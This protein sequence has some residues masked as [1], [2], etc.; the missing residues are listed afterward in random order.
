MP[1]TPLTLFKLI[2]RAVVVAIVTEDHHPQGV[3]SIIIERRWSMTTFNFVAIAAV[4]QNESSTH[5]H[6]I[7]GTLRESEVAPFFAQFVLV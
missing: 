5:R 7:L 4:V 6:K 3:G 2:L 1:S